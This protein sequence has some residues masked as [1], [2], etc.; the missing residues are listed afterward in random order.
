MNKTMKRMAADLELR[1]L[2]KGTK[3]SY[4]KRVRAF[5]EYFNRPAELLGEE[6]AR[7]Y[8]L[9]RKQRVQPS[10]LGVDIAAL[11][12]LYEV[13]LERPGV[14]A[15]IP[16]PKV[17]KKLPDILSGSEVI[18]VLAA[19][20]SFKHRTILTTAYGAGL[21]IHEACSL[22]PKDIDS[23]RMLIKVRNGKG[24]KDRYVMLAKNLLESLR[25]YWRVTRPRG[26][27]LFP[28][29]KP[30]THI[31]PDAVRAELRKALKKLDL[32]K[33]VTPHI[34][35]HSFA[36]HLIETGVDIRTIQA[37]LGHNSIR[38]TQLYTQVSTAH[39]ARIE[40][41]LDKLGTKEGR[42]LG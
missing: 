7:I 18:Q 22:H 31:T 3:D 36:T 35:R 10:T 15:R 19:I 41:P 5:L 9:D 24:G 4:R 16:W 42:V 30:D 34:L 40:S 20:E 8:L 26:P 17:P 6:E 37:V 32:T 14:V 33:R 12:F 13:T 39:V 27:W 29:Q 11:R 23:K 1:N 25:E 38:S 21:R 28:G 2:S